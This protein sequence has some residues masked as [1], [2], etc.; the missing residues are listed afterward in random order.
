MAG[1]WERRGR[2][3][4]RHLHSRLDCVY[5]EERHI[6]RR[7]RTAAREHRYGVRHLLALLLPLP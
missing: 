3:R 5:W 6:D 7:A 1:K 2:E 4:M